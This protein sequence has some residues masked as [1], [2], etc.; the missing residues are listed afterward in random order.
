MIGRILVPVD[1]SKESLRGIELASRLCGEHDRKVHMIHIVRH[2]KTPTEVLQY[3]RAEGVQ[4]S[5]E[6]V[7]LQLE[8]KHI[9]RL[10]EDRARELGLHPNSALLMG[11]PADEIIKYV[12]EFGIDTI[13]IG[14]NGAGRSNKDSL[15]SVCSRVCS[16]SDR[17]CIIVR[18]DLL[19]SKRILVVD[20]EQDVLDTIEEVLPQCAVTKASS[21]EEGKQLLQSSSF[22]MAILDIM[23]VKGYELLDIA[24]QVGILAVMLTGH[25]VS[26]ENTWRAYKGGAASYIPKDELANIDTYLKDVFEAQLKGKHSWW[27]WLDRFGLYY[28]KRF[29]PEW[30]SNVHAKDIKREE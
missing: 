13:I 11:E 22:D 19:Q 15:G 1:G 2:R 28:R 18:R 26:L 8:G 3:M 25:A 24:N 27:R 5:P 4:E 20:D 10:A 12:K 16:K 7:Y 14:A 6:S 17:T 23:G 9:I 29:G 21:F 30:Q